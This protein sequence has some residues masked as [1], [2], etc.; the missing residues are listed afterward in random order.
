MVF[1]AFLGR[2]KRVEE[3]RR[4]W[5]KERRAKKHLERFRKM[6]NGVETNRRGNKKIEMP[7]Y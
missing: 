6:W 7:K 1:F 2:K 4:N 3:S 5:K